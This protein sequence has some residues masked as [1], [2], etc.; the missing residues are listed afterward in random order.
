LG[1]ERL[2]G[3]GHC[4]DERDEPYARSLEPT[5]LHG[6]Y[7]PGFVHHDRVDHG[8]GE[9]QRPDEGDRPQSRTK[10]SQFGD[11]CAL[12]ELER[13][14]ASRGEATDEPDAGSRGVLGRNDGWVRRWHVCLRSE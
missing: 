13:D 9:G 8:D 14:D 2:L 6:K 4:A 11:S 5:S 12:D 1:P 10:E 7:V 3:N